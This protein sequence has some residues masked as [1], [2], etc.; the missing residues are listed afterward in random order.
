MEPE[1][2]TKVFNPDCEVKTD[3]SQFD[4]LSATRAALKASPIRWKYRHIQGHQDDLI[5][6]ELDH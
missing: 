4:L 5:D 1:L 3:R 2:S 6:V